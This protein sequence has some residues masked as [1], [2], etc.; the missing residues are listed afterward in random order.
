V[1]ELPDEGKT[2]RRRRS[3]NRARGRDVTIEPLDLRHARADVVPA[4]LEE[5]SKFPAVRSASN[6]GQV[7]TPK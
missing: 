4:G 6:S 1:I 7:T 3:R 2:S 5:L